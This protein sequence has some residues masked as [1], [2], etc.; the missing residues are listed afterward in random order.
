MST[1]CDVAIIGAGPA[2]IAAALALNERGVGRVVI[3][4]REAQAGGIPRHCGHATFGLTEFGWLMS[5]PSYAR[6]LVAKAKAAGV[7]VRTRT[8]VV[9]LKEGGE[10]T[11]SDP[12]AGITAI[13]ARRVLIATGIRETPRSARLVGGARP[14]GVL[15][16]G[17]LQNFIHLKNRT[18]FQRP[19]VIGTELVS[20][21]A[22]L[23][24]RH[25]GIRPQAMIEENDRP[26]AWSIFAAYPRLH[27]IALH[28]GTRVVEIHGR[29]RVDGVLV[30]SAAR[31][32]ETIACDGVLFTGKFVPAS[33]LVRQGPVDLD[34]ATQGPSVDQFGRLSNPAYYAAG[35]VL[36]PVE[37]SG[38]CYKEGR[39]IGHIIADDLA[40]KLPDAR[41]VITIER[42][43]GLKYIMPQRLA[44]GDNDHAHQALQLRVERS[45]R[46]RLLVEAQGQVV[47]SRPVSLKPE[48]RFLLP[49]SILEKYRSASSFRLSIIE[50]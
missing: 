34:P 36:R 30:E 21:S 27:G 1:E 43:Q 6:R 7:A 31:K 4:E 44:A 19:V 38:W 35:N 12:D 24:C 20:F 45:V 46:G 47:M 33:E 14:I 50:E 8:T 26:T 5:G 22:L 11:V 29:D 2:G 28:Y 16:T 41:G 40:G 37:T 13:T 42:G 48:R 25:A 3:L 49:L 10:I 39:E 9:T 15:T 17:A 32:S 23:T 18:P